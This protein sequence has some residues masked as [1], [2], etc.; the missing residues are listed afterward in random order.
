MIWIM[1]IKL[2][3][4]NTIRNKLKQIQ[5]PNKKERQ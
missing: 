1:R 2:K 4:Q 3:Q 5:N